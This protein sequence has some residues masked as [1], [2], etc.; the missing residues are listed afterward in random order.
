MAEV[1][2]KSDVDRIAQNLSNWGRWGIDDERGALNF[3]TTEIR[4]AALDLISDALVV[5]CVLAFVLPNAST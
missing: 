3:I 1:L 5:S 2:V 4:S